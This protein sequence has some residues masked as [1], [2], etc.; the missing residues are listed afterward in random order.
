MGIFKDEYGI[1]K[2]AAFPQPKQQLSL[3][4]LLKFFITINLRKIFARNLPLP[5][6][7]RNLMGRDFMATAQK[8]YKKP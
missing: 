8:V 3:I 4:L 2:L 1:L 5:T 7:Q 6:Y